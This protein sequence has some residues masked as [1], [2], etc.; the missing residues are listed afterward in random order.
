MYFLKIGL[1]I[2]KLKTHIVAKELLVAVT[3]GGAF[4][5]NTAASR[6]NTFLILLWC[7]NPLLNSQAIYL[8]LH[9]SE[10]Q[11]LLFSQLQPTPRQVVG[12]V[13]LLF[14]DQSV[15][16]QISESISE[17]VEATLHNPES[18]SPSFW[19]LQSKSRQAHF[20]SYQKRNISINPASNGQLKIY[21]AQARIA[22]IILF[23]FAVNTRAS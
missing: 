4:T 10:S 9:N 11:S 20:L 7:L 23:A 6:G 17:V 2:C 8:T 3:V 15:N 1:P 16:F 22:V 12:G 19:H 18:Q 13:H 21:L 14:C 5:A